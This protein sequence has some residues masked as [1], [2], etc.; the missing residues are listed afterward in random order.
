MSHTLAVM[1][2][3]QIVETGEAATIASDPQ[4]PYTKALFSA[5]LPTHPD[6]RRDEVVL[7]GEVPSPLN[8]PAGLPVP[9]ALPR[10]DA[11]VRDRGAQGSDGEGD[12]GRV[13]PLLE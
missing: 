5:A 6:E 9:P 7:S 4:H 13:S 8:P 1:Y 3:G 12:P 11:P 10:C 2:L